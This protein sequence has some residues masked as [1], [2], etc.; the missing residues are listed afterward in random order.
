MR[1][2][3]ILA[4]AT[5]VNCAAAYDPVFQ[6][7]RCPL[8]FS[9]DFD[10]TVPDQKPF[11]RTTVRLCYDTKTINLK[12]EAKDEK[13][14]YFDPEQKINDDIWKYEVMEAF[15][16]SGHADPSTYLEFEVSPNNITY[17]AFVYNPSKNRADGAPFDH[18]F[19]TNPI[20]DG[21]TSQTSLAQP[22]GK[23]T[24]E[25]RIPLALFNVDSARGSRWRMN[26]FRTVTSKEMYPDQILGAWNSPDKAS[27]HITSFFRKLVFV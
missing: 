7:P 8:R 25:V 4:V 16:S 14:F 9:L 24:S 5:A 22:Q 23:W 19:I 6:V 18:A 17:Q 3:T 27:F 2:N 15:I 10:K 26:F 20:A 21:I 11:P 12:F 1:F 13:Y